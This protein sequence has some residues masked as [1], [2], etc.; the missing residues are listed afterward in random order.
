MQSAADCFRI[1]R[2][3]N[4]FSRLCLLSTPPLGSVGSFEV[5]HSL[6]NLLNTG[7]EGDTLD[8]LP[9]DTNP[10]TNDEGNIICEINLNAEKF[11][12]CKAK[13]AHDA[14]IGRTDASVAKKN[15]QLRRPCIWK[16]KLLL[17]NYMMLLKQIFL[18]S[19][20]SWPKQSKTQFLAVSDHGSERNFARSKIAQTSTI[21]WTPSILPI[22][23]PTPDWRQR[24]TVVLYSTFWETR[25]RNFK[26]LLTPVT[27]FNLFQFQTLQWHECRHGSD[28]NLQ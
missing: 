23:R 7:A 17:R 26:N 2:K 12:L 14:V 25:R 16:P 21:S 1:D 8:E 13:A 27:F 11:R 10:V 15:W 4:Q 20:R 19:P 18:I 28:E 5:T 6:T 24:T 9:D 3:V 22:V